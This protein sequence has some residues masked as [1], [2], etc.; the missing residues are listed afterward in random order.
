MTFAFWKHW[1]SHGHHEVATPGQSK[2]LE[3]A[4]DLTS[5]VTRNPAPDASPPSEPTPSRTFTVPG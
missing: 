5:M 1:T 2:P 3:R 4:D